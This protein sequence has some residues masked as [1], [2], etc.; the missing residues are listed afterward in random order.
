MFLLVSKGEKKALKIGC[1]FA[2]NW[3]VTDVTL[4][5]CFRGG[6][7]CLNVRFRDSTILVTKTWF[8]S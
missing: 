2:V 5:P 3:L 6:L 1:A 4:H 8:E 7:T